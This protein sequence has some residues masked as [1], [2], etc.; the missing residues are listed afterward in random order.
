VR[1][2][3]PSNALDRL[4]PVDAGQHHIHQY[5]VERALRDPLSGRLAVTD[6]FRLMAKLGENRIEHDATE[7]I[8]LDTEKAQ[9]PRRSHRRTVIRPAT[10]RLRRLRAAQRYRERESGPAAPPRRHDDVATHGTRQRLHRRQSK[11]RAAEARRDADIG[12]RK[13]AKQPFDF[14]KREA[15]AAVGDRKGDANLALGATHRLDRERNAAR[16]RELHRVVDQVFQRGAQANG[17][18]DHK[19]GKFRRDIDLGLQTFRC[20][21]AGK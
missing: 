19:R 21:P 13:R 10:F 5:R 11:P 14:A 3:Q 17:I 20:C 15:D 18:A 9:T 1:R 4:N 16:F 8:V 2:A 7:R 12:L 6:E